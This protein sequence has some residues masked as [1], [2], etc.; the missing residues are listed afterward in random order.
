MRNRIFKGIFMVAVLVW[1]ACLTIIVGIIYSQYSSDYA[2]ELKTEAYLAARGVEESGMSYFQ[3]VT[4]P[5]GGR[6]TWVASDGTVLYD[7]YKD[8]S[9]LGNH[10]NR[11]EI[12]EAMKAGYSEDVRYSDTLSEKTMYCAVRLTDGTVLRIAKKQFTFLILL[13]SMWK[14]L[15]LVLLVAIFTSLMLASRISKKIV[16]P[17]ERIDLEHP[18][19]TAVYSELGGFVDKIAEQNQALNS[20][21]SRLKVDVDEKT[22]EA[23]FRKEFTANVSHELKTPLTSIS[24][25]AEIIKNGI[26]KEEDIPRFAGRIY[27][28][29]QRLITLVGDII[30]LSQLDEKQIPARKEKIDLYT[31]CE[32]V[33]ANLDHAAGEKN[34][35]IEM[36]GSHIFVESVEQILEEIIFNLCDNAIKYNKDGGSVKVSVFAT[37][38]GRPAVKVSDTGIGIPEDELDRIFERFYRVNKSHSKEIGGTGLGLSIVKHGAAYLEADVSVESSL[39]KGTS[40][41]ITFKN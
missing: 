1:A 37:D 5:N 34:V 3:D 23:D 16:E 25:F 29:A 8:A 20:Q 36:T 13:I 2:G 4:I 14:P 39:G 40:I 10:A 7:T 28:E 11:P 18:D 31:E 38:D 22:R 32:E 35:S 26:V 41:T 6:L 19:K 33:L 24:G 27:D 17:I 30:K 21:I 9:K 15:L 12:K